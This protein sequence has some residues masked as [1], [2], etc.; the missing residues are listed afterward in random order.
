MIFSILNTLSKMVDFPDSKF[1]Y[2]EIYLF[3]E[4]TDQIYTIDYSESD[5]YNIMNKCKSTPYR[6]FQKDYKEYVYKDLEAQY[7]HEDGIKVA[8]STL[9]HYDEK[10][11]YVVLYFNRQ[12]LTPMNFPS[13]IKF[14]KIT[15]VRKLTFRVNNRIYINFVCSLDDE[16]D[17]KTYSIYLNYNHEENVDMT[18]TKK[19]INEC[20]QM[21]TT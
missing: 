16:T 7:H 17:L 13:A 18:S 5:F 6:F 14:E 15:Y 12:K 2:V 8:R 21:L 10:A 11:K 3:K 9:V 20:I 19:T 4:K 1:N